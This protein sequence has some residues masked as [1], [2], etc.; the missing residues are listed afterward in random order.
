MV[1]TTLPTVAPMSSSAVEW[2]YTGPIKDVCKLCACTKLSNDMANNICFSTISD[3]LTFPDK[4]VQILSEAIQ[5]GL[6]LLQSW[7]VT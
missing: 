3:I 6:Y 4:D 2:K 1:P 5:T 7:D